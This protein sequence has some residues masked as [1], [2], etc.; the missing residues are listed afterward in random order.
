MFYTKDTNTSLAGFCDVDWAGSLDDRRSTSGGCLF[1]ENNMVSWNS[2]IQKCVLLSTAEAEYI[3][4]GS[5]CTQLLWMKHM[6]ADYGMDSNPLLVH[7]ENQSAINISKNP[8]MHS[9]TKHIAIR[10]HFVRDLVEGKIVVIEYV[11]TSRQLADI[12]TKALDLN[13]FLNL[14]KAIGIC[15]A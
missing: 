5:C 13:T 4:L 11:P 6:L 12:F 1:F 10:Y 7:C 15:E 3:A 2:K 8:V 9:K 14:K